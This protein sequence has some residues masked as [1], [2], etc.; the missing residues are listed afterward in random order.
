M[1]PCFEFHE[2]TLTV[3]TNNSGRECHQWEP[4]P[5]AYLAAK[6]YTA[7]FVP[8]HQYCHVCHALRI[9]RMLPAL[10]IDTLLVIKAIKQCMLHL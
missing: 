8:A 2:T 9:R 4:W 10:V 1:H 3:P 6:K 7:I 5:Y